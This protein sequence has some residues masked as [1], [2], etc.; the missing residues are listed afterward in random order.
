VEQKSNIE[1]GLGINPKNPYTLVQKRQYYNGT[2]NHENHNDNPDYWDYLLGDLKN[3]SLWHGKT[4]LD[5]ACG[6]GRNI[7]NMHNLCEWN[8][9]DG[10]DISD[11]NISYCKFAYTGLRSNFYCNNGIDISELK[12]DEY[13]F[14]MSTIALQHIPVYDIRKSLIQDINRVM[15]PGALFSF[16]LGFGHDLVDSLGRPKSSYYENAYGA[17]ETNSGHDVRVLDEKEV[18]D[19]L[20]NLNFSNVTTIV[21]PS[22]SDVGHP[23][24]IYVKA[25]KTK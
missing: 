23:Y 6:K 10:V 14:V 9:V 16:Q 19:D 11:R 21:R 13:D 20:N 12:S 18:I 3:K 8:R 25:Y 24:W 5:F 7:I 22:F 2:S 4:G 15:K 17:R 1:H